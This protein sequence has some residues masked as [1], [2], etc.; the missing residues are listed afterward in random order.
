MKFYFVFYKRISRDVI[1][2]E[3]NILF[4]DLR[5]KAFYVDIY[6]DNCSHM[7]KNNLIFKSFFEIKEKIY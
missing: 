6:D 7:Q 3:G 5:Q 2:E 4:F 1:R